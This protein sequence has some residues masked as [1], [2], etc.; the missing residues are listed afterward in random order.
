MPQSSFQDHYVIL[1][2]KFGAS[3]NAIKNAFRALAREHH[4]DKT[5]SADSTT[6]RAIRDAHDKLMDADTRA[7]YD[8][9]YWR[10]KFQ[11]DP[12][13]HRPGAGYTRT[14]QFEAD[15]QPRTRP[16]S[17]P[18]KKP[19][20]KS[21]EQGWK[22]LNGNA[23]KKW[24]RLMTEYSVR[25]PEYRD[26]VYESQPPSPGPGAVA[27]SLVVNMSHSCVLQ[28]VAIERNPFSGLGGKVMYT[29]SGA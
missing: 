18:P 5:G 22:Y 4:P 29:A 17:P 1:G 9:T 28:I 3:N 21:G 26:P 8:R 10:D 15:T 14:D 2:L 23:Y 11:T 27:H 7:G 19:V 16:I 20:K 25:H 6:F 12:P 13:V 24:Q